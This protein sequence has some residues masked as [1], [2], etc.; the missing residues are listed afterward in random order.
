MM[1]IVPPIRRRFGDENREKIPLTYPSEFVFYE[2]EA[3][4]YLGVL[5][6]Y[7]KILG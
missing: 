7:F 4:E 2:T 1:A 6:S 5:G 3:F